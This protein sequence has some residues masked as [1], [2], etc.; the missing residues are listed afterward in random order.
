MDLS[1]LKDDLRE[2]YFNRSS[3]WVPDIPYFDNP[4]SK[5]VWK[6]GPIFTERETNGDDDITRA[7]VTETCG[8]CVVTQAKGPNPGLQGI[9]KIRMQYSICLSV[10]FQH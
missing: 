8:T 3:Y 1:E 10:Q 7:Y 5:I 4:R 9:A 2:L 6:L